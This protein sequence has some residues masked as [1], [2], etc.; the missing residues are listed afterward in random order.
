MS[1]ATVTVTVEWA[2][3]GTLPSQGGFGVLHHSQGRLGSDDFREIA[4]RFRLGTFRELPQATIVWAP[5]NGGYVGL[6]IHERSSELDWLHRAT[7]TTRYFCVPYSELAATPVSYETLYEVL[8][9]CRLPVEGDLVTDLPVLDIEAAAASVTD[10]SLAIAALLLTG[11]PVCVIGA[12]DL[13]MAERLR[14]IDLVADLLPHGLRARFSAATWTDNATTH[15][16]RLAFADHPADRAVTVDWNGEIE[17]PADPSHDL[18]RYLLAEMRK[19]PV[20][21]LVRAFAQ[22]TEPLAFRDV[23]NRCLTLLDRFGRPEIEHSSDVGQTSVGTLVE[24]CVRHADSGEHGFL[25][26]RLRMLAFLIRN[27]EFSAEER[28][29]A[30]RVLLH[31]D[32]FAKRVEL[33]DIVEEQFYGVLLD[34]A[35][36]ATLTAESVDRI[37]ESATTLTEP[38][39][40]ALR[41]RSH[42]DAGVTLK[43]ARHSVSQRPGLGFSSLSSADLV[44]A[45]AWETSDPATLRSVCIE[46]TRRGQLRSEARLIAEALARH[47]Y[48]QETI[49]G[50]YPDDV[51]SQIG[52][53]R[54]LLRSGHGTD[55]DASALKAVMDGVDNAPSPAMRVALAMECGIDAQDFLMWS[56]YLQTLRRE[57]IPDEIL[58]R[59]AANGDGTQTDQPTGAHT[60][61]FRRRRH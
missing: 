18:T 10:R 28:E 29:D 38:L 55:L 5:K 15:R 44:G 39:V 51:E 23:W 21:D 22:A 11:N 54:E 16:I 4:E 43:L 9:A 42:A 14:C 7:V 27:R 56:V 34:A 49:P 2:I 36:G 32:V 60:G 46:L 31:N 30:F 8:S 13:P 26:Q 1:E 50:L 47:G 41:A 37:V 40:M 6:A 24:E 48:L 25:T 33:P 19:R 45:A 12:D 53:F 61:I 52:L 20:D 57:G 58:S 35:L 17:L 59:I 3:W